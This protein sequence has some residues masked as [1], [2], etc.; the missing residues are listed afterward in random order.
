MSVNKRP[1]ESTKVIQN[2]SNMG[3]HDDN[4]RGRVGLHAQSQVFGKNI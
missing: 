4:D 1:E 3:G 2:N